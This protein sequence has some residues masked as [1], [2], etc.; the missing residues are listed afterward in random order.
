M[1]PAAGRRD[2]VSTLLARFDASIALCSEAACLS[3][4]AYYYQPRG[5]DDTELIDALLAL[6][7]KHPRWRFPKC[8]KRLRALGYRWNHKRI[9]RVY[10]QLKF[11]MRRKG[12]RRLPSRHPLPLAVPMTSNICWSMDFMSDVLQHGHRFRT[13]NVV[14]DF[15][16]DVLG[17]DIN[18]GITADA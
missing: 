6:V 2:W 15:N 16:R 12:K 1:R 14:D 13:F 3:R 8:R 7:D 18:S 10:L 17:I 11:N 9:Y 5:V 4:S